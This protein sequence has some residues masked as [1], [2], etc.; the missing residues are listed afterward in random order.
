MI[1][2]ICSIKMLTQFIL[3]T[4]GK[5]VLETLFYVSA[6]DLLGKSVIQLAI[7]QNVEFGIWRLSELEIIIN[8]EW[9]TCGINMILMLKQ[10]L[11]N[12]EYKY[13]NILKITSTDISLIY[14]RWVTNSKG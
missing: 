8:F 14:S 13:E 3:T 9:N 6:I 7:T 10:S 5:Y 2:D 1:F 11:I 4:Q 12:I